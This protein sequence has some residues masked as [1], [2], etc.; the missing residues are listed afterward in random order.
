[1]VQPLPVFNGG[2]LIGA[3]DAQRADH[4]LQWSALADVLWQQSADLNAQLADHALCPGA[5][6]RTAHRGSMSCQYALILLRWIGR[7][8]EEFLTG[9]VVDVGEARLPEAGPDK[10]L[11][12]DLSQLHDALNQ[13]RRERRLTWTQLADEIGCTPSRLTNLRTARLADM[14][15]T[16]RICQWLG[17]PA[18]SFDHPATW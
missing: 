11:R 9:E 12:W 14:G 8:P 5:L 18:A 6:V 4:E 1:V 17:K 3:L 7:A 2:A 15:L 16:M 10:R 13:R